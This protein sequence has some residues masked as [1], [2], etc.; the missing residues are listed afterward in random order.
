MIGARGWI[1]LT[2]DRNIRRRELEIVAFANARVRG[3]VL[4]AADLTGPEQADAFVRAL[5]KMNRMAGGSRGPLIGRVGAK[6][7]VSMLRL[8]RSRSKKPVK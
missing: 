4:T 3:F 2:K 8:P 5:P 7:G 6:G 1:V